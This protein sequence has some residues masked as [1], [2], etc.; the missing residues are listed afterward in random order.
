[1]YGYILCTWWEDRAMLASNPSAKN[2]RNGAGGLFPK[3][4]SRPPVLHVAVGKKAKNAFYN[5]DKTHHIPT[6]FLGGE[7]I[8]LIIF[9]V[10]CK[11]RGL[12]L[13]SVSLRIKM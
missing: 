1:M 12:F 6:N 9:R 10:I 7:P 13:K 8:K 4:L 11:I 3:T 2:V 5:A